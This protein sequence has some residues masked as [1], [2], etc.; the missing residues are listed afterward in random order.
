MA[1]GK[2][3]R[4]GVPN[5]SGIILFPTLFLYFFFRICEGTKDPKVVLRE[6]IDKYKNVFQE[7]MRQVS[8]RSFNVYI[9]LFK[10]WEFQI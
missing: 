7:A 1:L 3:I 2:D 10:E 6:Q 5:D 9:P 8:L 4:D